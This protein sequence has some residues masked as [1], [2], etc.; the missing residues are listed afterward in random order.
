MEEEDKSKLEL[1]AFKSFNATPELVYII[2]FLNKSLKDRK[3]MFGL[4]K[5]KDKNEMT[6]NIYEV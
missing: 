4:S 2:D 6:V 5:V 1:I 3:L